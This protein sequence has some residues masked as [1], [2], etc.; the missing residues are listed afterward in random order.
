MKTVYHHR[1]NLGYN[2]SNL[3]SLSSFT[4]ASFEEENQP[5]HLYLFSI[6]ISLSL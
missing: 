6:F 3:I 5:L 4:V 2:D 1:L